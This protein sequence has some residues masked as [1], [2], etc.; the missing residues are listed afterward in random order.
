MGVNILTNQGSDHRQEAAAVI[1]LMP[2]CGYLSETSRMIELWRALTRRGT[3]VRMALHGGRHQDLVRAA[4]IPF[5]QVGPPMSAERSLQL[6]RD[7]PGL[8]DVRQSVYTRRELAEYAVAEADHLRRVGARAV[9]TGFTLTTLLSSRLAGVPL[10]TEHN[11]SWLPPVWEHGLLPAPA[12]PPW[13]WLRALPEPI[14][15]RLVNAAP[16][17]VRWYCAQIDA[18][19]RELGVAPVPSTAAL[20]LGDVALLTEVPQ[21]VGLPAAAFTGWRPAG[22]RGYRPGTRLAVAGPLWARL[23][24]PLPPDVE[25]STPAEL[26]RR[27]VQAVLRAAPDARVLVAGTVHAARDLRLQAGAGPGD[28]SGDR[29][30]VGGV[31]PSHLVMPRVRLAVTTAGQGSLQTAMAAGTPVIGIPLQPEQDLNV[32][33][34]ERLGAAVRV[35]PS[36][37]GSP[38]MAAAVRSAL[39]GNSPLRA[40]AQQV[41]RWYDEVDGADAAAR[42]IE[43]V[44]AGAA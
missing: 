42:A 2:Q 7:S 29:V 38:A 9:V 41:R 22:R 27:T 24:I 12:D 10:V 16:P 13:A 28:R 30:M 17:R 37:V 25:A 4:G 15:R 8:G 44:A 3:D 31:L 43:Q 36:A 14:L 18:V 20:T 23:P 33:L 5:D 26:V 35:A 40:G 19:A 32:V 34:L 6:V 11:G 1:V 21:V 39:A